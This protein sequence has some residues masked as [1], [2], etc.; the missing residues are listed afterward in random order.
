MGKD[1]KMKEHSRGGGM[2]T[3]VILLGLGLLFMLNNF[4]VVYLE[5]SWP[6]ILVIVGAG[7]IVGT[8]LR[9][10]AHQPETHTPPV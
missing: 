10:R 2:T 1:K 5:Q 3:G 6:L 4:D 8:F 9:R 7:L